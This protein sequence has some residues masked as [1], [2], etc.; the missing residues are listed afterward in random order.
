MVEQITPVKKEKKNKN[1]KASSSQD[2]RSEIV[3]NKGFNVD[4]KQ[5]QLEKEL[6]Q[7]KKL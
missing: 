1:K 4:A 7:L 5:I 3:L 6:Q 2:K